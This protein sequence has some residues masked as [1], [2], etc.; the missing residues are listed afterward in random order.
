LLLFVVVN[1]NGSGGI[2]QSRQ[3]FTPT[4]APVAVSRGYDDRLGAAGN[5]SSRSTTAAAHRAPLS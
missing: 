3:I 5:R 1:E 4:A 2:C